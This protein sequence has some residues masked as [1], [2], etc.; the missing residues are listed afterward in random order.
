M[1]LGKFILDQSGAYHGKLKAYGL[2]E[3]TIMLSPMTSQKGKPY[4]QI[5]GD[6]V[7]GAFDG[8]A[9]FPKK[10]GDLEFLSV[11][12]DSPMFQTPINAALFQDKA[13]PDI[14]NLVWDRPEPKPSLTANATQQA[15][16]QAEVP[17]KANFFQRLP[18]FAPKQ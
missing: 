3:T 11:T 14:Y 4:Y 12:L 6:P 16:P 7:Q 13:N 2:S 10:S 17:V 5:T 8:G 9:A 18:E 15:E 1:I